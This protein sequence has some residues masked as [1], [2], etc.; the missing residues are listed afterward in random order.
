MAVARAATVMAVAEIVRHAI[1]LVIVSIAT[2]AASAR[3]VR[4]MLKELAL[5]VLVTASAHHVEEKEESGMAIN[6]VTAMSA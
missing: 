2:E 1:I 5:N 3:N 4:A 6:F